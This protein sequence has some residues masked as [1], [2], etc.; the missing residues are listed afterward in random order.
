MRQQQAAALCKEYLLPLAGQLFH[1]LLPQRDAAP[2]QL[3]HGPVGTFEL[4]QRTEHAGGGKAGGAR[5]TVIRRRAGSGIE[6]SNL[7]AGMRQLPGQQPAQ[8]TGSG[9]AD[10]RRRRGGGGRNGRS[11]HAGI[12]LPLS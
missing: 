4:G 3:G 8:H 1:M 11:S 2:A 9:N 10:A 6:Y 5:L 7:V 12:M